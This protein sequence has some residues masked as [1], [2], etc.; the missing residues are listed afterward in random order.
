MVNLL[1]V[2]HGDL[3]DGMLSAMQLIVGQQEGVIAI[4][5]KETDSIDEL[6]SRVDA[7]VEELHASGSVLLLVD[8]FGASPFNTCVKLLTKY[9]DLQVVTGMNLPMLLE[10]VVQREGQSV[11]DL[12]KLASEAGKN[13]IRTLRELMDQAAQV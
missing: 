6:G 7:A 1:L 11:E 10:T 2:S 8:L 5:L 4:S 9:P 12:A 3:A 13:G